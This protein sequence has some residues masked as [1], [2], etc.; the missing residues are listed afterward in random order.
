MALVAVLGLGA[1]KATGGGYVGDPV[2]SQA[3]EAV[4]TGDATSASTSPARW[5]GQEEDRDQGPDHLPRRPQPVNVGASYRADRLPGDQAP[6][7]VEPIIF[8]GVTEC[9]AI[10]SC[11]SVTVRGRRVRGHSGG[12]VRGHLPV[13]G[14]DALRSARPGEFTVL[15]CD[16]GEP[17]R[18]R[19]DFTGDRFSIELI[20]GPYAVYTRGG[21]IEGGNIQVDNT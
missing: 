20:G 2:W 7:Q 12:P 9:G 21:Y 18:Q 10:G 13:P 15:V 14:H 16:Q 1:C 5:N 19:G 3:F 17:G 8:L 6:R 4:Y 11:S